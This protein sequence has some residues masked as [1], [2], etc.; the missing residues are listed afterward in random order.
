[1]EPI[2]PRRVSLLDVVRL[3]RPSQWTKNA[4]V[5]AGFFFAFWD[6]T[7]PVTLEDG[8]TLALPA[9][10]LFCLLS[11][12]V[13][14]LND[15]RDAG[16]DRAHPVKKLRPI[17]AGR[18][19]AALGSW[20][21][22]LLLG[23]GLAG[24]FVL[25]PEFALV[26]CAYV[27]IQVAYSLGLKR[28]A[29][30]DIFVI[31]TGFVLRAIAGAVVLGVAISPWL[32]LCAFLL[33]LFLVL[34]KRRHEK[35]LLDDD[36]AALHRESLDGYNER[37]LDQLITMAGA[38]TMVCYAMYT[39]SPGTVAK[40]GSARM[41]LTIPFVVFGIFRYMDLAYRHETGGRPEKILLSDVPILV[42]LLL[43]AAVI[44]LIFTV[45]RPS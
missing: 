21:C 3:L 11:S 9:A 13:Y 43:Y 29:L 8:W 23:T 27:A 2:E 38:A 39:L 24:A 12:G 18:V 15:I 1:M 19:P 26:A 4:V 20:L 33:A 17:A 36:A 5:L 44:F 31:S 10:A 45:G 22:V 25:S 14:V 41:G 37:L 30:L 16:S 28:V 42:D 34:C 6:K 35:I 40:F 32:L 7:Q